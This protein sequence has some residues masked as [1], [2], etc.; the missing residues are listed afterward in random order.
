[1]LKTCFWHGFKH[2]NMGARNWKNSVWIQLFYTDFIVLWLKV[3]SLFLLL[4]GMEIQA[5][6]I[7]KN[8]TELSRKLR[9]LLGVLWPLLR[10]FMNQEPLVDARKLWKTHP[11]QPTT[12]LS[13]CPLVGGSDLFPAKRIDLRKASIQLPSGSWIA[14]ISSELLRYLKFLY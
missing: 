11:T 4:C 2:K 6:R 14:N 8:L 12:C 5:K 13:S 1:M 7:G 9:R 3:F 10:Q